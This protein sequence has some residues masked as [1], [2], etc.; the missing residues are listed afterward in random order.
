MNAI[1]VD[2]LVA[3]LAQLLFERTA[4]ARGEHITIHCYA[5]R[6]FGVLIELG[7]ADL[8]AVPDGNWLIKPSQ[9]LKDKAAAS[10]FI[11]AVVSGTSY[12]PILAAAF[13]VAG[14]APSNP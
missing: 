6:V 7:F 4:V 8:V 10:R 12:F 2:P 5:R 1:T 9:L 11:P 3:F 13:D 14:K